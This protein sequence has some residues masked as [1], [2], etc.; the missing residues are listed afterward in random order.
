MNWYHNTQFSDPDDDGILLSATCQNCGA[1]FYVYADAL[2]DGMIPGGELC[3]DCEQSRSRVQGL[4]PSE[5][6]I[7][8]KPVMITVEPSGSLT[9][10]AADEATCTVDYHRWLIIIGK[11]KCDVCGSPLRR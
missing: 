7:D 2:I 11:N 5:I 3:G 10:R 6:W 1:M 9:R 8:D 4:E